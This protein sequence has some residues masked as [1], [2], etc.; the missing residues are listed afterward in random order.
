ML[1]RRGAPKTARVL[2]LL[3]QGGTIDAIALEAGCSPAY[4]SQIKRKL[5]KADEVP[6][7][8]EEPVW[9]LRR[10]VRNNHGTPRPLVDRLGPHDH[11]VELDGGE[12]TIE[13]AGDCALVALHEEGWSA[14]VVRGDRDDLTDLIEQLTTVRDQLPEVVT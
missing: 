8:A 9:R 10:E 14:A 11:L 7:R 13:R 2:D 4:V 1:G 6:G 12:I 5:Q 3:G